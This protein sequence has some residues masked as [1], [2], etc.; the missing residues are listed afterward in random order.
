MRGMESSVLISGE[1]IAERVAQLGAEISRWANM[2]GAD[3][4]GVG[5]AGQSDDGRLALLWL[6]DGAFIFA[7]DLARS[8]DAQMTVCSL[9]AS[10]YGASVKSSGRVVFDADL[11]KFADK[12]VLLVD[13]I[14]DTGRTLAEISAALRS[15]GVAELKTCVLLRKVFGGS[16]GCGYA[17]PDFVGFE[18]PDKF[19]FGYGLDYEYKFRNLRDIMSLERA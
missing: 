13:D 3:C 2:S 14:F 8:I 11:S 18:I 10:S 17:A 19:V 4:A 5:G 15:A 7:A 1:R 6:A 12:K 16:R 9:R